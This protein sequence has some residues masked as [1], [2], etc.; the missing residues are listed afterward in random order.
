MKQHAPS[1]TD[2]ARLRSESVADAPIPF[3]EQDHADGLYDPNDPVKVES[4]LRAA[5]VIRP[6]RGPQKAPVKKL[7]SLRL[8]QDVLEFYRSQ[9]KGWQTAIDETLRRSM[10]RS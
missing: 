7:I 3:D 8:S 2:W 9:G 4:A 5:T 6:K 10:R 1:K